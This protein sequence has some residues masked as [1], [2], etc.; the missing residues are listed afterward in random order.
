M[1]FPVSYFVAHIIAVTE[2]I[3]LLPIIAI[4]PLSAVIDS[5]VFA[6]ALLLL[7]SNILHK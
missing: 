3:V 7:L 5:I 1:L 4:L 6:A 2:T